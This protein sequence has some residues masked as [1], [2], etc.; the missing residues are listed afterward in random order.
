[1]GHLRSL[2]GPEITRDQHDQAHSDLRYGMSEPE[3]GTLMRHV[4][5]AHAAYS[6]GDFHGAHESLVNARNAAIYG[7]GSTRALQHVI[8]SAIGRQAPGSEISWGEGMG[9][10]LDEMRLSR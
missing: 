9:S 7:S 5:Q 8:P 3:S 10:A 1:M 6:S 4:A 2:A